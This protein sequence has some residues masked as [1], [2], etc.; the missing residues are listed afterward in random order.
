[1]TVSDVLK[2][3]SRI[4]AIEAE[5]LLAFVLRKDRAWLMAHND[6]RV[7]SG[8]IRAFRKLV[9]RR[10]AHEPIA[11]LIRYREFYRRRFAVNKHVLIPRPET[12]LLVERAL[13]LMSIAGASVL[14][15][16]GTGSGAIAVTVAA[17]RPD[18]PVLA[19]D[20]SGRA[21]LVAKHNARTHAP[22]RIAFLKSNLL[23]PN[24]YRWLA[25]HAH[26]NAT[27]V[28]AA[29]LPYLPLSDK[30]ILAPDVTTF[31]P[32]LA[33]FSGSDGLTLIKKF[34]GQIARHAP[35]W[36]Y[37]HVMLLFEFD[38]PQAKGLRALATTFFPHKK[39]AIWR[40]L[41][42]RNRLLEVTL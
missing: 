3:A 31:E 22:R 6:E 42:G 7:G 5:I 34:L 8:V 36:G 40:D 4:D 25:R 26:N 37:G 20:V 10:A 17:E 18:V 23:Q 11:H 16:V 12:E 2:D 15:D 41:A 24:A 32:S 29:N 21:L 9:V 19:T 27:L 13:A 1:M 14:W 28:I 33:L 38:P 35:E 39:I 30:K